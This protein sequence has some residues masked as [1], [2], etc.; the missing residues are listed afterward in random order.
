MA[1][2]PKSLEEQFDGQAEAE[3]MPIA[4]YY[5]ELK[6]QDKSVHWE[7][8]IVDKDDEEDLFIGWAE[9]LTNRSNYIEVDPIRAEDGEDATNQVIQ[10]IKE[11]I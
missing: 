9:E 4:K 10:K 3:L 5:F 1:N 2:Q 11:H 7:I 8:S 6:R